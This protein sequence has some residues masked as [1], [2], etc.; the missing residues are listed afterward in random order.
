MITHIKAIMLWFCCIA[1]LSPV[2]VY[3]QNKHVIKKDSVELHI[4]YKQAEPGDTLT[5]RIGT[6]FIAELSIGPVKEYT[7]IQDKKGMYLFKVPVSDKGGYFDLHA[8]KKKFKIGQNTKRPITE[9]QFWEAGDK[10]NIEIDNIEKAAGIHSICKFEGKNAFNYQA[11]QELTSLAINFEGTEPYIT[12]TKLPDSISKRLAFYKPK[13][14][15]LAY[16]ILEIEL[17]YSIV[18]NY[19]SGLVF[20]SKIAA[21][22]PKAKELY[23]LVKSNPQESIPLDAYR[24]KTYLLYKI[25]LAKLFS[26]FDAAVK[27]NLYKSIITNNTGMTKELLIVHYFEGYFK[28][29][30]ILKEYNS[31]MFEVK[32]P[33]LKNYLKNYR[34]KLP[35]LQWADYEL[36]DTN[37]KKVNLS[38]F[39][40]KIVLIDFWFTGCGY[41]ALYYTNVLSKIKEE[42]KG[43][44]VVFLSI[45]LDRSFESWKKSIAGGEYTDNKARN[46]Y[47]SGLGFAHPIAK[48]NG[49]NGG[50]YVV[51]LSKNRLLYQYNT[52]NLYKID[53]LKNTLTTLLSK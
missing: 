23:K 11:R 21:E 53:Q 5:L 48:E 16:R 4:N 8:L 32:D 3:A 22:N 34:Y 41:C 29:V 40:D 14:S 7:A 20:D 49:I 10:I 37:G 35:G 6:N 42:F 44:D 36:T 13:M 47:T 25:K 39:D 31:A 30:D 26:V 33:I 9:L 52:K 12:N 15:A 2:Y 18:G 46:F 1:L 24:S 19:V 38:Q 28:P 51:L 45:S 17:K 43:T 50:P 27:N